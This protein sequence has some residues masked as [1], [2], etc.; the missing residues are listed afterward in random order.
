MT[1]ET[2]ANGIDLSEADNT[3]MQQLFA[4]IAAGDEPL[5]ASADRAL[6]LMLGWAAQETWRFPEL[7]RDAI[8]GFDP[9]QVHSAVFGYRQHDGALLI[10]PNALATYL[11]EHGLSAKQVRAE[12]AQRGWLE[13]DADKQTAKLIRLARDRVRMVVLRPEILTGE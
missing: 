4:S 7:N 9:K 13:I 10:H 12:W 1:T 8:G 5:Q 6:E 3:T 2:M 11:L